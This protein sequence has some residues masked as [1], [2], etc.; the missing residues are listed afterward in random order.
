[1][2]TLLIPDVH[3]RHKSV[4]MIIKHEDPDKVIFMGDHFDQFG[5]NE[6]DNRKA[7]MWIVTRMKAFPKDDWIWG[8]HD[9]SYGWT[10]RYTKCSGYDFHKDVAINNIMGRENWD[11]FKFHVWL[12]DK[13]LVSHAGL[14]PVHACKDRDV[15]LPDWLEQSE[16][17]AIKALRNEQR[18]WMFAAGQARGGMEPKGGIN[19]LDWNVE[20]EPIDGI[21]QIVGHTVVREPSL[22]EGKDSWNYNLD[23][24]GNHYGIWDG[25][26]LKIVYARDE[27][28]GFKPE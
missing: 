19:W 23:T 5:D 11:R 17:F 3:L 14:H 15:S 20:F 4:E 10:S 9:T 24:N 22:K 7:A 16:K 2:M 6:A 18:H 27:V 28:P 21:N 12:D 25:K 1:M 13:T 26:K 8:N